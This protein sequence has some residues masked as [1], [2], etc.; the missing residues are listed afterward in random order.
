MD[1]IV[2]LSHKLNS[3]TQI[4]PGDPKFSC[5]PCATVSKDGYSVHSISLGSH[6]GTHIDA[7]SHFFE[8]QATVDQIPLS[9]LIAPLVV[10]DLSCRNLQERQIISWDDL[11]PF[12]GLIRPGV[13]L[14][15]YTG[16]SAFW[17]TPKYFN[18]PFLVKDTVEKIM[19]RGVKI[20]GVDTLSPDETE[21][22]GVGGQYGYGVHETILGAGGFIVENLTNLGNLRGQTHVAIVPLNLEGVDGSPVRAFA[23]KAH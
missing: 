6:T 2:D 4:Y 9:S 21:Y 20:I 22:Q 14:V 11:I 19:E 5:N 23:W 18:H 16:W 15:L 13:I 12:E 8:N 10:L 7:P 3:D 17:A 1:C